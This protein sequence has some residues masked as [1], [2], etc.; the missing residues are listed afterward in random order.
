MDVLME[1]FDMSMTTMSAGG[2]KQSILFDRFSTVVRDAEE[3]FALLV[4]ENNF[5]RWVYQAEIH[6]M[7]FDAEDNFGTVLPPSA[8]VPDVLYQNKVKKRRDNVETVGK[9][10]A[11]GIRRYNKILNDVILRRE[12]REEFEDSLMEE[13][14]KDI[15]DEH[16]DRIGILK[17]KMEAGEEEVIKKPKRE[18]VMDVLKIEE[19]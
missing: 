8:D 12:D 10:T 4:L 3:A 19:L 5:D 13:Y 16:K 1:Y 6:R 14:N 2:Y 18:L 7:K 17:R 9:W 11:E 15:S